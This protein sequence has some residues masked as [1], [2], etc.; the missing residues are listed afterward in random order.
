MIFIRV[1]M[2]SALNG[3][4]RQPGTF[5]LSLFSKTISRALARPRGCILIGSLFHEY[6]NALARDIISDFQAR[7]IDFLKITVN[8]WILKI[9]EKKNTAIKV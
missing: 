3:R 7:L 6:S 1:E 8:E 2:V 9:V 4:M 5:N